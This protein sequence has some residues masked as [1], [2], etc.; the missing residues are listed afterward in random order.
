MIQLTNTDDK[1]HMYYISSQ[2]LMTGQI[3]EHTAWVFH[4]YCMSIA[5]TL[6]WMICGIS[7]VNEYMG[8]AWVSHILYTELYAGLHGYMSTWILH[9]YC[10]DIAWV[11]HILYTR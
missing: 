2:V 10:M 7:L 5:H 3:L 9:G 4:G 6:Q 11:S 1:T 8:I